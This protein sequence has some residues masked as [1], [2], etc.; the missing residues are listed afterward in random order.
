MPIVKD[1]GQKAR[2]GERVAHRASAGMN[3]HRAAAASRWQP[4][5]CYEFSNVAGTV[6]G[7]HLGASEVPAFFCGQGYRIDLGGGAPTRIQAICGGL[8]VRAC[9]LALEFTVAVCYTLVS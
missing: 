9:L 2:V 5:T 7:R 8:R 3:R 6:L 1:N 4:P